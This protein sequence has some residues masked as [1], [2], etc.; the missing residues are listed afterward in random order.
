LLAFGYLEDLQGIALGNGLH[1]A[2]SHQTGM[3]EKKKFGLFG[4]R[5]ADDRKKLLN[6]YPQKTKD[7]IFEYL[8]EP[9]PLTSLSFIF[10]EIT[11]SLFLYI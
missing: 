2:V 10:R 8:L 11:H 5:G 3:I 6:I 9:A 7:N 4:F 1:T